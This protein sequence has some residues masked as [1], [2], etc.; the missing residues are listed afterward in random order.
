MRGRVVRQTKKGKKA[1]GPT[2]AEF[3]QVLSNIV[4][5]LDAYDECEWV[6]EWIAPYGGWHLYYDNDQLH[7]SA[8]KSGAL[9]RLG[10]A[11]MVVN[12]RPTYS[13]DFNRA[14][15]HTFGRM[16][17]LFQRQLRMVKGNLTMN[18]IKILLRRC[19]EDVTGPGVIAA[20]VCDLP[21]MFRIIGAPTDV[22]VHKGVHGT[23]G[24]V[25]P[26]KYR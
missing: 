3:E 12:P 23:A 16:W 18:T 8:E 9:Q 22:E 1:K 2:A 4:E 5:E 24:N 11:D 20:D 25:P 15:E 7:T 6:Q 17:Q 10:I 26:K 14:I 21:D 19:F 13:P